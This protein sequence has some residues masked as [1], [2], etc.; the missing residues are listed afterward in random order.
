MLNIF[1]VWF[2]SVVRE[3]ATCDHIIVDLSL[4]GGGRDRPDDQWGARE[5]ARMDIHK[6]IFC[7]QYCFGDCC[8]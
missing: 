6:F 8:M 7:N 2:G 3:L 1:C 5:F 4:V